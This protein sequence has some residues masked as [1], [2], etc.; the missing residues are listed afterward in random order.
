MKDKMK[1]LSGLV[2]TAGKA[3]KDLV[4]NAIQ[5]A[6]QNDDGKFDMSDVSAIAETVGRA[7]KKGTEVVKETA[8]EKA[9]QIELKTLAPVFSDNLVDADF[10]M[11]KFIRVAD[12]DK[13][14]AESEVCQGSIGYC[15]E[16]KGL[17]IVNVF[18]DSTEAFGLSFYPDSDSEF[19]YVD[20]TDR[21]R[22]IALD[23]YFSYLKVARVNEL[24]MI[25]QSLGA[26][27]FRVTYKEEQVAFSEN[28][29]KGHVQAG[30]VGTGDVD[31]SSME[32]KY[33]TVD[34][35]AEMSFPG[36]APMKPAL[37]Y[38]QRDPSIQTLIAMRM[39]EKAPL[40]NQKYMLK[41]SNSSGMKEADAIKIDAVI[42]GFKLSGNATVASEAKN[43]SRR[44]LEYVIEF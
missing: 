16:Q 6:D 25:A 20:P 35:A 10:I 33:S 19:Y 21:D 42:K 11:P 4:D 23:E 30:I 22:Y 27:Y 38:M 12:R 1:K 15:S 41:M 3:A 9:K 24:Q 17:H 37:K 18:R 7:M 32:K 36:H 44:Y 8:T 14:R 13:R 43:E 29:I 39:D 2:S 40:M 28:K 26:K 34:I 31:H 5:M